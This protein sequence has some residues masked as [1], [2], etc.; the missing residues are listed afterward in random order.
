MSA[1]DYLSVAANALQVINFADTVFRIGRNLYELFDKA[2]SASRNIA[3]LLLELQALL[4]VVACV[5]VYIEEHAS[6]PFAQ[7]DG[8]AL[9][10]IRTLLTLIEQEFRHLRALFLQ[11]TSPGQ[12]CWSSYLPSNFKWALRDQAIADARHRFSQHTLHLNAALSVSGRRND[13]VLRD[14][15][16]QIEEKL[17]IISQSSPIT[18]LGSQ[19]HTIPA[20]LRIISQTP[21]R[22]AGASPLMLRFNTIDSILIANCTKIEVCERP[23]WTLFYGSSNKAF[24][25]VSMP[26]ILVRELLLALFDMKIIHSD[27][28][29]TKTEIN[30]LLVLLDCLVAAALTPAPETGTRK[31]Y[32]HDGAKVYQFVS[33]DKSGK[34]IP[35]RIHSKA[36]IHLMKE[37]VP[38]FSIETSNSKLGLDSF[39]ATLAKLRTKKNYLVFRVIFIGQRWEKWA[40]M[41]NVCPRY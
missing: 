4:S 38:T 18:Q 3:L 25:D 17:C 39:K 16:Q 20:N 32:D 36:M 24:R 15:L 23:G 35:F 14:R 31:Y 37:Y 6:S 34:N 21:S 8:L 22:L 2:Q 10:N 33:Q 9:P 41:V 28:N 30:T 40:V 5:R 29:I 13:I 11:T 12:R 26:S 19:C 27:I 7:V 1:L